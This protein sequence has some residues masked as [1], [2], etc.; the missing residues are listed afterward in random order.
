MSQQ[1]TQPQE[2][3]PQRYYPFYVRIHWFAKG[4]TAGYTDAGQDDE[5]T[6]QQYAKIRSRTVRGVIEVIGMRPA[7]H[8]ITAYSSG[9]ELTDAA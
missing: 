2:A 8:V 7:P 3:A 6:A 4:D 5:A 9:E 1:Q